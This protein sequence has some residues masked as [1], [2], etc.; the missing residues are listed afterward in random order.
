[1]WTRQLILNSGEIFY[2][3]R[4]DA[5]NA[6]Y[7]LSGGYSQTGNPFPSD[8]FGKDL[9][10]YS[11]KFSAAF[12]GN[13]M[14]YNFN[15]A[16]GYSYFSALAGI[17]RNGRYSKENMASLAV[18]GEQG[19]DLPSGK[20]VKLTGGFDVKCGEEALGAGDYPGRLM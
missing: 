16:A 19:F 4:Y 11:G 15:A 7:S 10:D 20:K 3:T 8:I 12:S 6:A 2:S 14:D 13:I 9:S 17:G 5:Y 18:S 1:M